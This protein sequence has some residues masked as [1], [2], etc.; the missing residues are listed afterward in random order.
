MKE[1]PKRKYEVW[2]RIAGDSEQDIKDSLDQIMF[3]FHEK[4][5]VRGPIVSGS[6]SASFSVELEINPEQTHENY[7]AQLQTYLGKT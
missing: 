3:A 2:I 5:G 6:P 7:F 1:K 4:A